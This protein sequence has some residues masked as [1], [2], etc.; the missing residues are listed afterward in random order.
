VIILTNKQFNQNA[1]EALEELKLEI[2]NE[3]DANLTNAEVSDGAMIRDLG[4][5]AEKQ[6][7]DKDTFNPS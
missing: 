2:A 6:L 5:K 4:A 1:K 7:S 3:L